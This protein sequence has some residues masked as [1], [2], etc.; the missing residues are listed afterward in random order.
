MQQT[1]G[2]RF[3]FAVGT[4]ACLALRCFGAV[5]L[6]PVGYESISLGFALA[7]KKLLA[8]FLL[9]CASVSMH[10]CIIYVGGCTDAYWLQSTILVSVFFLFGE[11]L[12]MYGE[13]L[14]AG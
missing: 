6:F 13:Y 8:S 5:V 14:G 3:E 12:K 9:N 1:L 10:G 11:K 2:F 4:L 7:G